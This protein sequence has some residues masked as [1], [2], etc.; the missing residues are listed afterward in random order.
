VRNADG[1]PVALDPGNPTMRDALRESIVGMLSPEGLDADG[2]KIDFTARTPAGRALSHEGAAWGIALLHELLAL[3]YRAAKEAKP[4][5]LV[6]T[7][8]PHPAFVDVT[9]MVRLND[10]LRMDDPGPMP[11]VVP[12]MRFRADVVRAACPEIPIDTDDWCVPDLRT[13]RAYA[14]EKLELGVPSLYYVTHLD[15]SG[16]R[17]EPEDYEV[18]RRT[19]D[20]W[21][22]RQSTARA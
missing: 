12:Q 8:T 20:T 9:D 4:D 11:P 17:L 16:E 19:W 14:E 21:R 1:A 6:I 22:K 7:Q 3:V 18:L 2:L 15:A 10:M 13:W 5:A